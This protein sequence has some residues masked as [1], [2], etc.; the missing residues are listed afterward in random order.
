MGPK[1]NHPGDKIGCM[2]QYQ[3]SPHVPKVTS[4]THCRPD[5]KVAAP[6]RRCF[7]GLIKKPCPRR[8]PIRHS[9]GARQVGKRSTLPISSIRTMQRNRAHAGQEDLLPR[10]SSLTASTVP[11]FG[12]F[13]LSFQKIECRQFL[14]DSFRAVLG[15]FRE[16][17]F[18]SWP[19]RRL[20]LGL[21]SIFGPGMRCYLKKAHCEVDHSISTT[22]SG[23]GAFMSAAT[24]FARELPIAKAML[25]KNVKVEGHIRSQEDLT[26]EGEVEGTIDMIDHCLTIAANGKVRAHVKVREIE[27]F[28]SIEGKIEAVDKVYI[29]KSAQLVGDIHSASIIIRRRWVH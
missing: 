21:A 29:R 27:V 11:P 12:R 28:G 6:L 26:I 17:D 15:Q 13:D 9:P 19:G 16:A 5:K 23:Q 1:G 25:G 7:V 22:E 8:V 4:R 18:A 10:S 24:S 3:R 14:L 2:W 20:L